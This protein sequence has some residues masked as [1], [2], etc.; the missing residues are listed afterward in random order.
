[1]YFI[2]IVLLMSNLERFLD[3]FN[4]TLSKHAPL[5]KN[6][7]KKKMSHSMSIILEVPV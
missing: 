5:K 6:L 4:I 2:I 3:I 7:E 1:M